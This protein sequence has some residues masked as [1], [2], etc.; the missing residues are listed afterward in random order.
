MRL[1]DAKVKKQFKWRYKTFFTSSVSH[2]FIVENLVD[3]YLIIRD[4]LQNQKLCFTSE[5]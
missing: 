5:K 3:F 1:Q 2:Y 4:T